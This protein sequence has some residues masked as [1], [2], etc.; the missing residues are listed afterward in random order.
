VAVIVMAVAVIV[1]V[2]VDDCAHLMSFT[3]CVL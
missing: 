3:F 1:I 2:R